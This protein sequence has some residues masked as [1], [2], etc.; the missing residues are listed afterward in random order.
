MK[1]IVYTEY[2]NPDVLHLNDVEKPSPKDNEVL[3]KILATS[4]NAADWHLLTADIF[5]VRLNMGLFK[6]KNTTLGCD[7]AGRVEAV[8]SGVRQF[9][10]G[11]AVFGDVFGH[12]YGGFAEY[13]TAAENDLA[14]KP[15]NLP[16]E[17]AAAVSLAA[18]TALQGL[19]DQGHIQAGRLP[20]RLPN[21]TGLK[22]RR[23]AVPAM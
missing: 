5:L 10:P 1:A 2:G 22:S 15:A 11:D 3:V 18:K 13:V 6:P 16:F 7:I 4:V 20:C 17:E 12:H 23:C 14:L 19:R 8:G 9:K 21:T